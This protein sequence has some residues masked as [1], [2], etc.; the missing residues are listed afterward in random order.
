[1]NVCTKLHGK[2]SNNCQDISVWTKRAQSHTTSYHHCPK[3]FLPFLHQGIMRIQFACLLLVLLSVTVLSLD[4][5]IKGQFKKFK[6]QHINEQMTV[7][8]CDDVMRRRNIDKVHKNKCK[9]INTF[10]RASI[11]T[12]K[13]ICGR[14]G[15]K[16]DDMRKS[17]E[18]F[19]IVVCKLKNPSAKYPNC[20][21]S[22]KALTKRIIIKCVKG[23][24]VHYD[25]D[26][27]HC[28]N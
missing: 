6:N 9:K 28:E 25:G 14:A 18:R 15:E 24:P 1:M 27:G 16:Y 23:F 3:I 22:G 4:V 11:T 26:I 5:D 13:P 7:N 2:L 12:V 20:H 17:V 8:Q 21:Y 19:D 10:I